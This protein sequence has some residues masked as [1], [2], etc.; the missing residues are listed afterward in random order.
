MDQSITLPV[1]SGLETR[2]KE[3][4]WSFV[5]DGPPLAVVA[6]LFG[7]LLAIWLPLHWLMVGGTVVLGVA[8]LLVLLQVRTWP[9]L[10]G[11]DRQKALTSLASLDNRCRAAQAR[12]IERNR[13]R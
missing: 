3:R 11:A 9:W 4:A 12:R 1:E 7:A 2:S 13:W 6:P 10:P 8:C 5:K